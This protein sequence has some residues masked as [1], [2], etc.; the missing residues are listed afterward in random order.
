MSMSEILSVLTSKARTEAEEAQRAVIHALNGLA[1][2]MLIEVPW[3]E[4]YPGGVMAG[5]AASGAVRPVISQ[6]HVL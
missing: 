5:A 3:G 2:L 4:G 1:G 6:K